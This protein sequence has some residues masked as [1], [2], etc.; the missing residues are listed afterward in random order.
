MAMSENKARSLRGEMYYA[1]TPAL[2]AER[3][4]CQTALQRYNNSDA[5]TRRKR[6]ELWRE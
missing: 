4:R 6:A 1:F 2:V 5:L 3:R